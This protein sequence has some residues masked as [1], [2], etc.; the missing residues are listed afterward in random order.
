MVLLQVEER[1]RGVSREAV[2]VGSE[3]RALSSPQHQPRSDVLSKGTVGPPS[4][5]SADTREAKGA[6][7]RSG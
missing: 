2:S 4:C 7:R 5:L 3:Q 1:R 6:E